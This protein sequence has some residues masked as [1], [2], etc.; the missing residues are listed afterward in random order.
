[1]DTKRWWICEFCGKCLSSYQCLWKHKKR[2]HRPKHKEK[3]GIQMNLQ[4]NNLVIIKLNYETIMGLLTTHGVMMGNFHRN[5]LVMN[6]CHRTMSRR[7]MICLIIHYVTMEQLKRTTLFN[8][9]A[10]YVQ[11]LLV[12]LGLAKQ[13]Y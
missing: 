4:I 3:V 5:C 10:I 8:C 6:Q 7:Y 2:F 13:R 9:H 11:L 1:M 12:N